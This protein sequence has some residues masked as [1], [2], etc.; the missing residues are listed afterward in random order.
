MLALPATST[1][2][3][4]PRAWQSPCTT[5]ASA[6]T[7]RTRFMPCPRYALPQGNSRV[8]SPPGPVLY[9]RAPDA[10]AP[11][12]P[13]LARQVGGQ[14]AARGDAASGAR[15]RANRRAPSRTAGTGGGD[16]GGGG[17]VGRPARQASAA[18][19]ARCREC[20][21]RDAG[22]LRPRLRGPVG[23]A[24]QRRA[25]SG[26]VPATRAAHRTALPQCSSSLLAAGRRR[27]VRRVPGGRAGVVGAAGRANAPG[28][29]TL[30]R[31]GHRRI[32]EQA[33]SERLV[34]R[35]PRPTSL[36][37]AGQ[38]R[39]CPASRGPR[40]RARRPLHGEAVRSPTRR[41]PAEAFELVAALPAAGLRR[42][43]GRGVDDRRR[44]RRSAHTA[45]VAEPTPH[46]L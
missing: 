31:A 22:G 32:D 36:T 11:L 28:Q 6:S 7:S 4:P 40:S 38:D 15:A 19:G 26:S 43:R 33:D 16:P 9:L 44:A 17:R 27:P 41:D 18:P 45:R 14:G 10:P 30:R 34:L 46:L 39:G 24:P 2:K 13:A 20:H 5:S 37:V 1:S 25:H 42:Q 29:G 12:V 23:V 3:W 35:L 8:V 21:A